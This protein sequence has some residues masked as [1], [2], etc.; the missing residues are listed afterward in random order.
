[1]TYLFPAL[2][3]NVPYSLHRRTAKVASKLSC[4]ASHLFENINKAAGRNSLAL[5]FH[6]RYGCIIN[7]TL[8]SD[9]SKCPS[10]NHENNHQQ[11]RP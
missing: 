10:D 5:I 3:V 9:I 6:T 2:P 1:M 7:L 11:C 8:N 4:A